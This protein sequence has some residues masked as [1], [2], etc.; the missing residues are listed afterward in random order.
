M[1]DTRLLVRQPHVYDVAIQNRCALLDI[2]IPS[3]LRWFAY[4]W[5]ISISSSDKRHS[6]IRAAMATLVA[7][8]A[9]ENINV[10]NDPLLGLILIA[11]WR[12]IFDETKPDSFNGSL[13]WRLA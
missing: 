3:N 13:M 10:I 7:I 5:Q 6:R 1:V 4:D 9:R 2:I 8:F 11:P 12:T